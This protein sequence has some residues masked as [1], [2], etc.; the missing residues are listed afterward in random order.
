MAELAP[1]PGLLARLSAERAEALLDVGPAPGAPRP[2]LL[3]AVRREG[4]R[5]GIRRT[6]IRI[7]VAAAA[8]AV[9][10][11]AVLAPLAFTRPGAG[12]PRRRIREVPDAAGG[13]RRE[14]RFTP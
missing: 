13:R 9:V 8:A 14:Y 6:R 12:A 2:E 4:R 3:D 7:A 1:I 10:L 5:R 11:A